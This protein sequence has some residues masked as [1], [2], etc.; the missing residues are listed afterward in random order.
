MS[1]AGT[2][3]S[4]RDRRAP[5][6]VVVTVGGLNVG[7]GSDVDGSGG[8]VVGVKTL[9]VDAPGTVV[10]ASS[11]VITASGTSASTSKPHSF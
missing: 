9:D 5:Q 7:G 2:T 1:M 3:P 11:G 10:T 6:G 4:G 8:D